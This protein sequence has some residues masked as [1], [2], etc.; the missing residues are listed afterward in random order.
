MNSASAIICYRNKILLFH[1]DNKPKVFPDHWQLPGGG[2]EKGETPLQ[3]LKRELVEEVSYI[4]KKISF[5]AKV[6]R[7]DGITYV[8]TSF[9]DR[10]ETKRFKIGKTEGKEIGFFSINKALTLKLTPA[11]K[12]YLL[13]Y[14]NQ[15]NQALRTKNFSKMSL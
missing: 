15:I 7:K 3:R 12:K 1:R 2:I 6:R 14:K 9:V 5:L 8:Y 10:E 4:P 13:I 11:L